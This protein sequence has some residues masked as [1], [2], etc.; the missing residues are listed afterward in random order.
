MIKKKINHFCGFMFKGIQAFRIEFFF[1]LKVANIR[2]F[3][4]IAVEIFVISYVNSLEGRK[5][6]AVLFS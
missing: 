1:I 4:L 6:V 3:I 2:C 5:Y